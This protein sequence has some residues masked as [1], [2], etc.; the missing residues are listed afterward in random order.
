[1]R[2]CSALVH[3]DAL[4]EQVAHARLGEELLV[5]GRKERTTAQRAE[6]SAVRIDTIP[7]QLVYK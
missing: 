1:M 4:E 7:W 6:R 3:V 5:C 2:T